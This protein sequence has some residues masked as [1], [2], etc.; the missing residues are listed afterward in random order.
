MSCH[1]WRHIKSILTNFVR[2]F[3]ALLC[4]SIVICFTQSN[5]TFSTLSHGFLMIKYKKCIIVLFISSYHF[6][7][8]VLLK[9]DSPMWNDYIFTSLAHKAVTSD[10]SGQSLDLSPC[11][12]VVPY[13]FLNWPPPGLVLSF[14]LSLSFGV[15][16]IDIIGVEVECIL[17]AINKISYGVEKT[18]SLKGVYLVWD[19]FRHFE[20]SASFRRT[21]AH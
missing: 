12:I 2:R 15:H 16:I 17:H 8:F 3:T 14:S 19:D 9:Y 7:F 21:A 5:L 13:F 1:H 10:F 20:R 18:F 6:C 4:I 11:P